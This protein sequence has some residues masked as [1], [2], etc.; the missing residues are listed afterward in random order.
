MDKRE[1]DGLTNSDVGNLSDVLG[2]ERTTG[3]PPKPAALDTGPGGPAP[4]PPPPP[5]QNDEPIP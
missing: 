5:P 3:K 1:K 2:V 4:P